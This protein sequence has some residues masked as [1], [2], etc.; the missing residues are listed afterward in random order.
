[1]A[2]TVA[3]IEA[4]ERCPEADILILEK[5]PDR[6]VGG[7]GRASGQTLFCPH[8]LDAVMHYQRNM[9][10]PNPIPESVL[11]VWAEAMVTQEPYIEDIARSAGMEYIHRG[12]VGGDTVIEFPEIGGREAVDYNST[13]DPNPC[14]V[15]N[16]F[17]AKLD[18]NPPRVLFETPVI[19][20]VQDPDTLEVFGVLAQQGDRQIAI[21]ARRAVVMCCGGYEND[22]EMQRNY[23]GIDRA[24]P[25]GTPGNTGDG[26]RILQ[27]AGA[28]LWHMKNQTQSGGLWPAIKVDEYEAAFMRNLRMDSGSWIEIARTGKRFYNETRAFAL[29]HYKE[30]VHGTWL[31]TP[32]ANVLPIHMIFDE[33]TRKSDCLITQWM[34]WNSVVEEYVWSEDNSAEIEKGWIA[35]AATLEE[36][37]DQM[38]RPPEDVIRAIDTFNADCARG[39]ADKFGRQPADMQPIDTPPYYA[40]EIVPGIVCTTGGGKRNEHSQ[41]LDAS[42]KPIP[43]LYE[44]GEL[45][46]TMAN[47]YQN[48]SFLTECM[49]FGRIAARHA[50]ALDVWDT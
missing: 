8:D 4:R 33:K 44:A 25:L 6:Y 40:V 14:G 31:D 47:L 49:V 18:S 36:L 26:I 13:I 46:S 3:A 48:G 12:R 24:Y 27:R 11:K 21:K 32:H 29:T 37:A 15:W 7:N 38:K 19:D 20:L 17:K 50:L 9:N 45:G 42:S 23:H 35:N 34:T 1:M 5:M 2:G 16:A 41:V 22:L 30:E 28:E 10:D 43:R 39:T